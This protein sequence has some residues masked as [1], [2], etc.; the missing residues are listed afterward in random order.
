MANE[1]LIAHTVTSGSDGD[2]DVGSSFDSGPLLPKQSYSLTF[3]EPGSY[4]YYCVYHPSMV[5]IIQVN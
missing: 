2:S 5:A 1:D 4:E 3:D